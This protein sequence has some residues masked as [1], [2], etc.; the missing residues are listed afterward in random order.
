MRIHRVGTH[1][2]RFGRGPLLQELILRHHV[3]ADHPA[4]LTHINL[5]G[6]VAVVGKLIFGQPP[7]IHEFPNINGHTRVIRDKIHQTFLVDFMFAKDS[8]TPFIGSLRVIVVTAN[9][10]RAEGAVV[11]GI[12]LVVGDSVE[13]AEASAPT[14]IKNAQDQFVLFG[15][16]PVWLRERNTIFRMICQAH[17]KAIRLHLF[18]ACTIFAGRLG[19]DARQHATLGIARH[20]V[21]TD[22]LFERA[23]MMAVM[24]HPCLHPVP[25]FAVGILRFPANM[26]IHSRRGHQVA[27]VGG[28][29][30]HFSVI[31]PA[32]KHGDGGDAPGLPGHALARRTL[33]PL[34]A[35]NGNLV[36]PHETLEHLL[37]HV[38]FEDPHRAHGPVN[39]R[40]ALP[41]VAVLFTF[42]PLPGFGLV[43]L[44]PKLMIK[45]TGKSADS[46]FV[47]GIGETQS[48]S[49]EPAQVFIRANDEGA[50]AHFPGLH[51]GNHSGA[52]A[53]VHD[54]V[55]HLGRGK[56]GA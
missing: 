45:F 15:V 23:K 19:A 36:L 27:L 43:V 4:R 39:G 35:M 3:F 24:Q 28:V 20:L 44:K 41:L 40:G 47:A 29:D 37:G 14:R 55:I 48:T 50:P 6:P 21:G 54:Q 11:V 25:L 26:I 9:I 31:H 33:K 52:R 42:L 38:R 34:I 5:V 1:P 13:L 51:R 30:E 12:G 2:N 22:L 17:A 16:I 10:V 53:A 56:G 49:R 18:V 7:F 32:A 8:G 46:L